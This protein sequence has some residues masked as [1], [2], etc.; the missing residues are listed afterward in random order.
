MS[1]PLSFRNTTNKHL[2]SAFIIGIC[3]KV[4]KAEPS[5]ICGRQ[6]LKN[7]KSDVSKNI[8]R[9]TLS[10]LLLLGRAHRATLLTIAL[11]QK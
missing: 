6:P 1:T 4:F 10:R 5:K 8:S 3:Y 7:S 9:K 2:N 11:S